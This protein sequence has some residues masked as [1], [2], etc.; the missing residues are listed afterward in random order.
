MSLF[1]RYEF[2]CEQILRARHA[3]EPNDGFQQQLQEER[4]ADQL[5]L[6]K[7]VE[8]EGLPDTAERLASHLGILN[9]FLKRKD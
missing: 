7:T 8:R 6:L 4:L 5:E 3:A 1:N 9:D 2:D